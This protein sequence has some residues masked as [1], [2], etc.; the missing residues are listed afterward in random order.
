[1]RV[2]FVCSGNVKFGTGD[3]IVSYTRSQGE[4]LKRKGT[5]LD[6]FSIKGRGIKNYFKHIFILKNFL[7][8]NKYDIIHA[9]YGLCGL[10]S[11]LTF[12]KVPIVVSFMGSDLYGDPDYKGKRRLSDFVFIFFNLLLQFRVDFIIVKSKI[13][14]EHVIKKKK[15]Q[16]IPNGVDFDFFKPIEKSKAMK[17]LS[18]SDKKKKY[19]L[20]LGDRSHPRK[21]FPLVEKALQRLSDVELLSPFPV[22]VEK[23]PLY[24]NTADVLVLTSFKEGSPN[25][26]K[27]AMAC[28]CPIVSTDVGDVREVIGSTMGC[29]ITSFEP[30]DVAEK[31]KLA[32]AFGQRT[33]GRDN[34]KHLENG[35][36][37]EK[38]S[39]IYESVVKK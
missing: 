18:I 35:I 11:V 31:L 16:I 17:E 26:I 4:S 2:L 6:F 13:L 22:L 34:I 21:N 20:F 28:N 39:K 19:I 14:A 9:H 30:E 36:I 3:G 29:Y 25:V 24:L 10:I 32:L 37:A 7:K 5:H 8:K 23:V 38:I 12:T 27:E 1:M 33:D 15:M